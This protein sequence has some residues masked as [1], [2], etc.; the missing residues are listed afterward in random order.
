MLN[1]F[2]NASHY[3]CVTLI[4]FQTLRKYISVEKNIPTYTSFETRLDVLTFKNQQSNK[5][6]T[7]KTRI[8]KKKH[9]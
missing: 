8:L 7:T 4:S 5:E 6:L 9:I 3:F 2:R 1:E